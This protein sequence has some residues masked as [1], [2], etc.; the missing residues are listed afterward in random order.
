MAFSLRYWYLCLRMKKADA[1]KKNAKKWAI[2]GRIV[3]AIVALAVI[4]VAISANEHSKLD[5]GT[6]NF[7]GIRLAAARHALVHVRKKHASEP[8][9]GWSWS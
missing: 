9:G 2:V 6:Q 4:V 7:S 1:T 5:D 3:G 8:Y